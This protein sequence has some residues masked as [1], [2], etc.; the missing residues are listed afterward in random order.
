M[1]ISLSYPQNSLEIMECGFVV[2]MTSQKH[3]KTLSVVEGELCE[4]I[5]RD[6]M[7]RKHY[8]SRPVW[9]HGASMLTI[10]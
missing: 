6:G 7:L 3:S 5:E 9:S 4:K 8:K 1:K 10:R 2:L